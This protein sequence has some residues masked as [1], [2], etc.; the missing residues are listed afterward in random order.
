MSSTLIYE[1][2]LYS[3]KFRNDVECGKYSDAQ[4]TQMVENNE[5]NAFQMK[6][7]QELAPNVQAQ[8]AQQQQQPQQA[9]PN[10]QPQGGYKPN[11]NAGK[12]VGAQ[13]WQAIVGS[14]KST[15]L[16]S[17]LQ[18]LQKAKPDDKYVVDVTQYIVQAFTQLNS[19]LSPAANR[20]AAPQ[21]QQQPQQATR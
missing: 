2:A 18:N 21:Q 1:Q 14:L 8:P 13:A 7:V 10:A 4:L 11:V 15:K 19:H 5:L 20:Q 17:Q 3:D 9:A 16:L 12:D 6:V